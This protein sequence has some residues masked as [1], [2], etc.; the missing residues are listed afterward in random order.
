MM[1][2][3]SV[4]FILFALG[5]AVSGQLNAEVFEVKNNGNTFTPDVIQV[6]PGD[7]INFNLGIYHDV[8]EVS[9][10]TWEA[11]GNES[12]GGFELPFGGGTLILQE[13]GTYYYV[14]TPHASL[15][16][17]GIIYVGGV[18]P[19]DAITRAD[20]HQ[21]RIFPNPVTDNINLS[22]ELAKISEVRIELVDLTGRTVRVLVN[23]RYEA[24]EYTQSFSLDGLQPGRYVVHIQTD[25]G[26]SIESITIIE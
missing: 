11:N 9:Q 12:N 6:N 14:C 21:F 19:A 15:G 26:N 20:D 7:T 16:M 1:K 22:F 10:S 2:K 18:T 17:K 3:R 13:Q 23:D 24:G 5:L 25:T 4:L 8:V